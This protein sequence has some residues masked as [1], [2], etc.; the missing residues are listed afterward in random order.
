[1]FKKAFT[2]VE[3]LIALLVLGTVAVVTIP[4]LLEYNKEKGWNTSSTIF[5]RNVAEAIALMN[6]QDKLG[7][8]TTTKDFVDNLSNYMTITR[9][10]TVV[11]ECFPSEFYE[12]SQNNP[13]NTK[14]LTRAENLNSKKNYGT[15]TMGVI[16]N[17]GIMAIIAYNPECK[18]DPYSNQSVKVTG[19]TDKK[20][21]VSVDTNCI[22][23]LYDL[24]GLA[25]PNMYVTDD[26]KK[27]DIRGINV[28]LRFE[29]PE[30]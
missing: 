7:R 5:E 6:T 10:C 24:N 21:S 22:S 2:L 15:E 30:G 13:L 14:R 18:T 9:K 12:N 29:E 3:V 25:M 17:N 8:Y 28:S 4:N 20:G 1:M 27:N 19:S 11:D 16:F 26:G 23:I